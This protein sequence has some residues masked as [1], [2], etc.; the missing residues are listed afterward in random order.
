MKNDVLV[1]CLN[2]YTNDDADDIK[3]KKADN[4]E[5]NYMLGI[6]NFLLNDK[7]TF[8]LLLSFVFNQIDTNIDNKTS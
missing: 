1:G 6:T 7:I 3:N 8:W 2:L 4:S 5:R